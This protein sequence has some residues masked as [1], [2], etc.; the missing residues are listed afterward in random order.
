VKTRSIKKSIPMLDLEVRF[1][2]DS[3]NVE[4]RTVEMIMT[5]SNPVRMFNWD[6]GE[7]VEVLSMK[8][9]HI[10]WRRAES[11]LAMLDCHW[12]FRIR[13]Q[14][15]VIEKV[16]L[17]GEQM[18]GL[19]RFSKRES[20]EDI[21]QDVVDRIYRNGSVGYRVHKY[22][23]ITQGDDA[24]LKT[25][26]AIDW[27]PMEMSLVPVGADA[28]AGVRSIDRERVA[29]ESEFTNECEIEIK[30]LSEQEDEMGKENEGQKETATPAAAA[31]DQKAI[32]DAATKAER[33]RVKEIRA[34]VKAAKLGE[35][36]ATELI[37]GE[38][39]ADAARAHI[40]ELLEKQNAETET[41]AINPSVTVGETG[42][43]AFIRD[44]GDWLM[45]RAGLSAMMEKSLGRKLNPG[46]FRGMS[47]FDLARESLI[48]S[49]VR[50]RGTDR[51]MLVGRA[52]TQRSVVA[53]G[54]SDFPYLLENVMHKILLGSYETQ[55]DTWSKFCARGTVSDFRAHNRYRA[56]SFGRLDALLENGEFKK[57]QIPDAEKA[58]VQADTVGNLITLSRKAVMNDDMGAFS[59]LATML[60]R[61]SRLSIE[62]DVYAALA[63]NSGFGPTMSDGKALF[64]DDH[65]NIAASAGV[66]TVATV[67]SCRT[68][69]AQQRDPSS[70]EYLHLVPAVWLGPTSLGGQARVVNDAQYD[71][72]TANKLQKPN[73]VR[74]LFRDV[75]DTPR[76]SGHPWFVF[77]D[78]NIAPVLEV[79]FLDG[80]DAP[81]LESKEGWSTDGVEWKVRL[82][83]GVDA[84]D[85]RGGVRNA[86]N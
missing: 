86:G 43:E 49:G 59:Q 81:V 23:D 25:F 80:Q 28:D 22:Q 60:G 7:F 68:T 17:D 16:W 67:E 53:Q 46:E 9:E 85:F 45:I 66:P 27:E 14:I 3:I 33:Q 39:T 62:I 61:A 13:D 48:M 78:P 35:E 31:V 44:A 79:S 20:V 82:D 12:R 73:M 75:V 70:N 84:V 57:K 54:S 36:V 76:L 56:G 55:P 5:T 69:L 4:A 21:F 64:H 26:L 30:A 2:P 58:T 37:D 10:R 72:D 15:G 47:L 63:E 83:Y 34:A 24:R 51:M 18:K 1:V 71:P 19:A 74:G 8:K 41:R 32:A 11:G 77:A 52:F 29:D 6:I 65:K 42:R 38:K 40:L 50:I